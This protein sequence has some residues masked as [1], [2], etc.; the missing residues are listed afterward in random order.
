MKNPKLIRVLF[1][2]LGN[3]CRSPAAHAVFQAMVNMAGLGEKFQID[4]A[5]ILDYHQG[6]LPDPR[7]QQTA[8]KRGYVLD[9]RS[10]PI[11]LADFSSYDVILAMDRDILRTLQEL[12]ESK[13]NN[14]TPT[15]KI[16]LF[17]D[18]LQNS[19]RGIDVP[20]PYWSGQEGFEH[21]MDLIEEG[22]EALFE[23]L[24]QGA[25]SCERE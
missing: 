15:A 25:L 11:A 1:V 2:C 9:H 3:I 17:T 18:F 13:A 21:V 10:R 8:K 7:M 19:H 16:C 20:D 14:R 5:G 24:T 6:E 22:C 4:S 23:A 12:L